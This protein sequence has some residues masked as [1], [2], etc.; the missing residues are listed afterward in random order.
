LQAPKI[1]FIE[2]KSP[3]GIV[4]GVLLQAINPKAYVVNTSLIT[5]FG[6]MP[7]NLTLEII[8]KILITNAIWI[9]LHLGWLYAGTLLHEL[10]PK[11][12]HATHH[13]HFD[14]AFDVDGCLF[15]RCLCPRARGIKGHQRPFS[16]S[17]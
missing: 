11:S 16:T 14:G 17:S 15:G 2:A 7:D 4:G 5:G 1:A 13:Q 10:K 8:L 3:P 6:F 12:A 9:P